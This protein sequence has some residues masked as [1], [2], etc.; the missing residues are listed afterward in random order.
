VI[1]SDQ[2][3]HEDSCH[4]EMAADVCII[5][6]GPAGLALASELVGSGVKIVIVERGP[7]GPPGPETPVGLHTGHPY[8]LDESRAF[9]AGGT[10]RLWFVDTPE[11]PGRVRLRELER[12]DIEGRSW[13]RQPAWAVRYEDIARWYPDARRLCGLGEKPADDTND[14]FV[15]ETDGRAQL[16]LFEF[17]LAE[18]FTEVLPRQVG[19]HPNVEVVYNMR[20]LALEGEDRE[21]FKAEGVLAQSHLTGHRI[22]V[23]A[24]IIVLCAG[25]AENVRLLLEPSSPRARELGNAGGQLGLGFMEHPNYAGGV[26]FP[27]HEWLRRTGVPTPF[28]Y[29]NGY[30]VER[31]YVLSEQ[32][33]E[34]HNLLGNHVRLHR[35][36]WSR[37]RFAKTVSGRQTPRGLSEIR[38]VAGSVRRREFGPVR[39]QLLA[40]VGDLPASWRHLQ[41]LLPHLAESRRAGL[42]QDALLFTCSAEQVRSPSSRVLLGECGSDGV[43]EATI[44]LQLG[45]VD[46]DS[47][48]RWP[49]VL[50]AIMEEAGIGRFVPLFDRS[51]APESLRWGHHHLGTTVMSQRPEDGVVDPD[52]RVHGTTNVYV[53]SSSVFPTG[54]YANP[55]LTIVALA[56]RLADHVRQRVGTSCA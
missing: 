1:V 8:N 39:R 46:L 20:A 22:R 7:A 12:A 10:A 9:G 30:L 25:A 40:A 16:S 31:R 27:R 23:T 19:S 52:G 28:E 17:G 2:R 3:L 48:E 24:S 32:V 18:S 34:R 51:S 45:D 54:G 4:Q 38:H 29:L 44:N 55:T 14:R 42:S 50:G 49:K 5:G 41:A 43:R 6:G 56:C 21:P 36:R 13:G 37:Y 15:S 33:L 11:G 47:M 53:C 26:L 35:R